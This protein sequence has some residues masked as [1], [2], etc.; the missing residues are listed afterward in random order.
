MKVFFHYVNRLRRNSHLH[1]KIFCPLLTLTYPLLS[2]I[3]SI[4]H[5]LLLVTMHLN[6]QQTNIFLRARKSSTHY[7]TFSSRPSC[8]TIQSH[9]NPTF[10]ASRLRNGITSQ[11]FDHYRRPTECNQYPMYNFLSNSLFSFTHSAYLGNITS[12]KEPHTYAQTILDP[13]WQK[14]LSALHLNQM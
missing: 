7:R 4:H 14:E 1:Y 11:S 8:S 3:H 5:L 2:D 13:N 6:L 12:T 9:I 10:L